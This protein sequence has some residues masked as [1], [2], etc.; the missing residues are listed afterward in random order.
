MRPNSPLIDADELLDLAA[1]LGVVL[2]PPAGGHG[3][4]HH[5][6]CRGGR[7][8][9]SSSSRS[10]A[11]QP[12]DDALGVVEPVDAEQHVLRRA[13]AVAQLPGL[14]DRLGHAG[15]LVELAPRRSRSGRRRRASCGARTSAPAGRRA[16]SSSR[17]AAAAKFSAATWRW[18]PMTSAPRR[19]SS[20]CS[21]HGSRLNS[22][23]GG[24][25]M[26][27]KKPIRTSGRSS[28]SMAGTSWSW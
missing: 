22:S 16:T 14:L 3:E 6:A 26:W 21:R 1:L 11:S 13:Q 7:C 19:P 24:N 8:G 15:E 20:T 12:L 23:A 4:L 2:E 5:H 18:K 10:K 25:G 17:L 28:R 27:R 9:R